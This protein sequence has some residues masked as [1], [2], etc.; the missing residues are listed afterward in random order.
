M[1]IDEKDLAIIN[2]LRT[3]SRQSI[4]QIAKKTRIRPSTVHLRINRLVN[5]GVIE[6]FT[7]K[8]NNK[9]FGENFIVFVLVK[10]TQEIRKNIFENPHVREVF[11]VTGEYDLLLKLKFESIEQFNDFLLTFRKEN[12]VS[13]SVTMVCTITLKEEI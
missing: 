10:S 3:N 9:I 8:L 6:K 12:A 7:L 11:G 4:R 13:S 5:Q 1:K 2:E